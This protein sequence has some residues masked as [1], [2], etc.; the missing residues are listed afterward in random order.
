[1]S[2]RQP[3]CLSQLEH[4]EAIN[5]LAQVDGVFDTARPRHDQGLG[6]ADL[7]SPGMFGWFI[8]APTFDAE[9]R[10]LI[11]A[12][13]LPAFSDRSWPAG[14]RHDDT[15]G[16]LLPTRSLLPSSI[17]HRVSIEFESDRDIG[18]DQRLSGASGSL[19]EL[20]P[21]RCG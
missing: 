5:G 8:R 17:G 1:V 3:R 14:D 15:I 13:A 4:H 6:N 11:A 12:T 16:I 19:Q 2:D 21:R 7:E 9:Q 10:D 18:D 20:C